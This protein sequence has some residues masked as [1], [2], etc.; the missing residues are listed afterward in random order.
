N[1]ASYDIPKYHFNVKAAYA[2]AARF[3]LYTR[4]Y[5]EA[6]AYAT[7]ALGGTVDKQLNILNEGVPVLRNFWRQSYNTSNSAVMA[8][9][10]AEEASN[11]MLIPT[12]SWYNI[13]RGS[14]FSINRDAKAATYYGH[15]PAWNTDFTHYYCHPCYA[16]SMY[17]R[18]SQ[19][20]GNFFIKGIYLFEYTDKIA[21]IGYGHN[22]RGEFTQEEALLTRAEARI[23]LGKEQQAIDDLQTWELN[24]ENNNVSGIQYRPVNRQTIDDFYG[25][26]TWI[27]S[28][29][30]KAGDVGY[31]I[32]NGIVKPL[33]IE[34]VHPSADY[35]YNPSMEN[36]LQCVLHFRRIETAEDGLRWFDIRR[37]G[38]EVTHNIGASQSVTLKWDDPRRCLQI[39]AEVISSG[40]QPN[41][42][43]LSAAEGQ[44]TQIKPSDL[45]VKY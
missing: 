35:P 39:P 4:R 17:I 7:L 8:Y 21:G 14:R 24:R 2:F 16:G 43:T 41:V 27:D 18:A 42:R 19:E 22:I 34:L 11:L 9:Y 15:G 36:L 30:Q 33:N 31:V 10:S 13:S 40:F 28:R 25:D 44:S 26:F 45:R 5:K 3:Y 23:W 1:D 29:D 20:Y 32:K 6:E 38:I 37:Y 12:M